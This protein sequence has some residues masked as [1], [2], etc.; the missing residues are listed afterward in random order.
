MKKNEKDATFRFDIFKEDGK[1]I[2]IEIT[3]DDYRKQL[4]GGIP[5]DE[6]LSVGFHKARRGGFRERHPNFDL[7]DVEIRITNQNSKQKTSVS[8]K[9]SKGK[10]A[11]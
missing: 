6:L 10:K 1:D 2:T 8:I 5:E 4:A 9:K 7:E 11:A 3:E